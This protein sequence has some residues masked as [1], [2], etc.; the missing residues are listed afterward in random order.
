[1]ASLINSTKNL[2]NKNSLQT[3][4][5]KKVEGE[6]EETLRTH[7]TKGNVTQLPNQEKTQQEQRTMQQ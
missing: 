3:L 2:K 4:P 6:E 1:M 7:P 5:E